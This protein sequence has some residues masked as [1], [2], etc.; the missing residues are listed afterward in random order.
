M[1]EV[2]QAAIERALEARTR[3]RR[4]PLRETA[5]ALAAAADRFRADAELARALPAA[6]ALS[7]AMV[8]AVLPLMAEPF[9]VDALV[10]LHAREATAGAPPT[11]VAAVLASNV[12]GLAL[13][14]IAHALL[15]G[16]AVLVKSGRADALSA[17]AFQ[18]ALAAVDPELAATVVT[19]AW[20]GG[21]TAVEDAVLARAD[22]VVASGADA[23]M[24]ALAR[25]YGPAVI[26]H[27]SRTS[28]AVVSSRATADEIAALALDVVR[29]EQRGCLSP[30]AVFVLGDPG[31]LAPPLRS[32]LDRLARELPPPPQSTADRAAHRLALEEARF[33]GAVVLE[34]GGTVI[35]DPRPSAVEGIGRRTV[36]LHG[37]AR[38]AE[39]LDAIP[40][41]AIE[42]VGTSQD[43]AL[44]VE[45][46]RRRG[47]ARVC[48]V[49]RMQRPRIDWPRG[50][51]PALASLFRVAGEPRIQVES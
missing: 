7:P 20:A 34:G 40:P 49:G 11:L 36:R 23:T 2:L 29:Y 1:I 31:A 3:L 28:L 44:D 22:V 5:A 6:A 47:V 10:S 9:D 12:P 8:R 24:A 30:H 14:P 19:A 41:G 16:A 38:P 27:G 39:V 35:V 33:A 26:A 4:R 37:I 48:P 17:P 42:C 51:R 18:R 50:Q 45:G 25:R 15:A 46:L 21:T 32:A 43:V 13:P